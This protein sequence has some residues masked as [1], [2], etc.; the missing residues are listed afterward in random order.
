MPVDLS[1]ENTRYAER[2]AWQALLGWPAECEEGFQRMPHYKEQDTGGVFVY[3]VADEKYL[4]FVTCTLGPYWVEEYIYLLD[5]T[6]G[7]PSARQL[8][9]PEL[10]QEGAQ[11]WTQ[12][13][14]YLIHG[15]FPSYQSDTKTLTNLVAFRGFKDCGFFYVYHLEQERFVLDEARYREECDDN[16]FI[17]SD[18]WEVIYRRSSTATSAVTPSP[19]TPLAT[20]GPYLVYKKNLDNH[21]NRPALVIVD[22]RGLGR[23][24]YTLPDGASA[25]NLAQAIS[26]DGKWLAFH[27]G[28]IE[29]GYDLA[30]NLMDMTNGQAQLLTPLLSASHPGNFRQAADLLAQQGITPI[31]GADSVILSSFLQAAFASGIHALAWSP[32]GRYLAFAGQMDGLSSDLYVYDTATHT[33]NRLSDGPEQIQSIEWSPDGK[34]ILHGSAFTRGEGTPIHYYAVAVDGSLM[35]SLSSSILGIQGW[36]ESATYLQSEANNGPAGTFDLQ[37]VNI[38]SGVATTLWGGTFESFAIDPQNKLLAVCGVEKVGGANPRALFLINLSDGS[39]RHIAERASDVKFLGAGDKRFIFRVVEGDAIKM[40]LIMAD[41]STFEAGYAGQ[42]TASPDQRYLLA[43]GQALHVYTADD[44]LVRAIALPEPGRAAGK[45]IWRPDSEGFFFT[46]GT[47]LYAAE[48]ANGQTALVDE[49]VPESQEFDY[50][51]VGAD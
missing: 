46:L 25:G 48:L 22:A 11:G 29:A 37:S 19:V 8:A 30:L 42:A 31:E 1:Q 27:T 9:V 28:S 47:R 24:I 2:P 50:I 23:K 45:I 39:Q 15:S 7:S 33:I 16:N 51:W 43:A 38:E 14:V 36:V 21:H 20:R 44:V 35:R 41:G 5:N 17:S 32:D 10:S 34:W 40:M 49:D 12:H 6:G 13:D 3:E 18:K 4:A 26:S